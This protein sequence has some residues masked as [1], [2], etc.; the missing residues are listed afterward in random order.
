ML[1]APGYFAI[2]SDSDYCKLQERKDRNL[3]IARPTNFSYR[4]EVHTSKGSK[5]GVYYNPY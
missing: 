3:K 1:Y 2:I 4:P 5:K